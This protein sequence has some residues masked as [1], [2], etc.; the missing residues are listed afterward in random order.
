MINRLQWTQLFSNIKFENTVKQY[1]NKYCF[2][3]VLFAPGGRSIYNKKYS[4]EQSIELRQQISKSYNYGGSWSYRHDKNSYL[5]L[6]DLLLLSHIK[7]Q[8]AEYRDR[9]KIRVE[10]PRITVYASSEAD[11][12]EFAKSLPGVSFDRV[13]LLSAPQDLSAMAQLET[14]A[15]LVS[16]PADYQYKITL[17]DTRLPVSAKLSILNYLIGLGT[18]ISLPKSCKIQ[19]ARNSTWLYN[20]Y[21]YCQDEKIITMLNLIAPDIVRSINSFVHKT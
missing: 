14:G 17:R 6:A 4:I 16:K 2:K 7:A 18:D 21:F 9:I 15:I 5:H 12:L 1:F 11:L 20:T 8:K 3:L 10:E 13:E 19:L